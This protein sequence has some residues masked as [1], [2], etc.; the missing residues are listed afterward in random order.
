MNAEFSADPLSTKPPDVFDVRTS[1]LQ[2]W[3]ACRVHAWIVVLCP[4]L[5][6]GL[7]TF[8]VL[9]WQPIYRANAALLAEPERDN[10]R[11]QF[12]H[13]WNMFRKEDLKSEVSLIT[14]NAVVGDVVKQLNLKYDDVYHPFFNHAAYLWTEST[15]GKIYR[16]MKRWIWPEKTGPY[17]PTEA[18][19]DFARTVSDLKEGIAI[20]PV[21]ESHVGLLTLKGPSPRVAEIANTLINTSLEHRRRRYIEEATEAYNALKQEHAKVYAEVLALEENRKRFYTENGLLMDFEREKIGVSNYT[22]LEST[23]GLLRTELVGLEEKRALLVKLVAAEPIETITQRTTQKNPLRYEIEKMR[24]MLE[25]QLADNLVR[26]REDAPEMMELKKRIAAIDGVI[27]G[28]AA[29]DELSSTKVLSST[30][31]SLDTQ[32]KNVEVEIAG[33][34]AS[35][36]AKEELLTAMKP[37]LTQISGKMVEMHHLSREEAGVEKKYLLLQERLA[38]AQVSISGARTAP[39]SIKVVD[40][41]EAP[42][43]PD[44]PKNKYLFPAAAFLGLFAGVALALLIELVSSRVTEARLKSHSQEYPLFATIRRRRGVPSLDLHLPRLRRRAFAE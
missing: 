37:R 38:M 15:V 8:Y 33:K 19:I 25:A 20:A 32:L 3:D 5:T 36:K 11:D 41:A 44:W 22:S 6:V 42:S 4:M 30:R 24:T 13:F 21:P 40:Y 9:N 7:I 14:S 23:I 31:E 12:Y 28:M 35:I 29:A 10:S 27:Q 18:E 17:T 2:I 1:L 39:A 26:Y 34:L 16:R 43:R